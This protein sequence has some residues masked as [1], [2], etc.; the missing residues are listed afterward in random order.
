HI[1]AA[2][3]E[4]LLWLGTPETFP[5]RNGRHVLQMTEELSEMLYLDSAEL[6]AIDHPADTRVFSTSKLLPGKPWLP[7][8]IVTVHN[9]I[10]LKHAT[11][12]V[13]E[14]VT[15]LLQNFDEARFAPEPF[16]DHL[17]GYAKPSQLTLDFGPLET[18]KP[19][20]LALN[21]WL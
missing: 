13:G 7:H 11:G 17:M 19:L 18:T 8:E 21:G 16:G 2:D 4:E 3:P 9:R 1:I 6:V 14:D 10:Q 20:V 5:A 15:P 12:T